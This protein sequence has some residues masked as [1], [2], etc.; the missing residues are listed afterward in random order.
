M[1]SRS[2]SCP[3]H[4]KNLSTFFYP[5]AKQQAIPAA[6]A[7]FTKDGSLYVGYGNKYRNK[8][9]S[10][11]IDPILLPLNQ[12]EYILS[13]GCYG[14]EMHLLTIGEELSLQK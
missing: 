5:Q 10:L 4:L 9:E 2:P 7:H 1:I 6:L 8:N 11:P 3:Q 12:K 13:E 14:T